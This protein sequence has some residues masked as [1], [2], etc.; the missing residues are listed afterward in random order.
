MSDPKTEW[1]LIPIIIIISNI[2]LK[3]LKFPLYGKK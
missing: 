2:I 1:L 3:L